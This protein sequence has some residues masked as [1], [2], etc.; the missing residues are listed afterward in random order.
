MLAALRFSGRAAGIHEKERGFG[1]QRDGFDDLVAIFFQ[2]IID[3]EVSAHDHR[4]VG[5]IFA[6]I[7]SPHQDL[8]DLLARFGCRFYRNIGAS[9]VVHPL[10]VAVVA[11][12]INQHAAAGIGGGEAAG[13]A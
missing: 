13:L 3:E 4:R 6:G 8:F 1:V 5:R 2:D 10:A 9:L 11:V 7:A 12:S